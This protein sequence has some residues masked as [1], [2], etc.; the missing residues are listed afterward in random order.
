[1]RPAT[2]IQFERIKN[3]LFRGFRNLGSVKVDS[4]FGGGSLQPAQL[5]LVAAPLVCDELATLET[6]DR[7]D[8]LRYLTR[9]NNVEQF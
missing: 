7:D 9:G 1:M 3:L 8:H 6:T 2:S 5:L 4:L